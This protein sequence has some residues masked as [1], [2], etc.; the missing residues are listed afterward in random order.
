MNLIGYVLTHS[1]NMNIFMWLL[2][3][4]HDLIYEEYILKN[5]YNKASIGFDIGNTTMM[6]FFPFNLFII[7]QFLIIN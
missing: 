2:N 5:N 6:Q 1:F 3:G 4:N 7:P